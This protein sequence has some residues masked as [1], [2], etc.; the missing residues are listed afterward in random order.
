METKIYKLLNQLMNISGTNEKLEYIKTN[1]SE[2]SELNNL[3]LDIMRIQFDPR[4][5]TNLAKKSM[6]KNNAKSF[7]ISIETVPEF[8]E[9]ISEE[10]TGKDIDI[11]NILNYLDLVEEFH[12][13]AVRNMFEDIAIQ[14]LKLGVTGKS[15]NTALNREEIYVFDVWKGHALK[16]YGKLKG[17][18]LIVTKKYDGYR[19]LIYKDLVF[20]PKGTAQPLSNFPEIE[21]EINKIAEGIRNK[22]IIDGEMLYNKEAIDRIDRYNKTSSIMGKDGVKR[23]LCFYSFDMLPYTEFKNEIAIEDSA[24]RKGR[25]KAVISELVGE[26][27]EL[28][29]AEPIYIGSDI[30]IVKELFMDSLRDGD[31]GLMLQTFDSKYE[32]RKVSDGIWKLKIRDT[33]DLKVLGFEEGKETGKNKGT[34]GMMYVE[35]KGFKCGVGTGFKELVD[36]EK[37]PVEHTRDWI[38]E[39]RDNL[40]GKI[41]EV[42][43]DENK[44]KDGGFNLRHGSFLRWRFDKTE[45]SL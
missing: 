30:D 24:T 17:R 22:F 20:S 5:T 42:E 8:L 27:E 4:I 23:D 36:D 38:W 32:T 21:L 13:E 16:D 9:Y 29:Y 1:L 41:V 18:D 12:G 31:E 43:Y 10:C 44:N 14:N 35:Y 3:I 2:K 45:P 40:I 25:L 33:G 26:S 15:V 6:K 19:S 34:L 11:A 39:N 28:K 37:Y 7:T